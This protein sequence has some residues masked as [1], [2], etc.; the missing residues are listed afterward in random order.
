MVGDEINTEIIANIK[1]E[2]PRLDQVK[3]FCYLDSQITNNNKSIK[4][5]K[6]IKALAKL[7]FQ[8]KQNSLVNQNLSISI[9]KKFIKAFV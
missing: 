8:R 7:A 6:K 5:I 3:I 2:D 9:E 4:N 1:I